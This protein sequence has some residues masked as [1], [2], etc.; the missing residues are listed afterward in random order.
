MKLRE[1]TCFLTAI[2][3]LRSFFGL[4]ATNVKEQRTGASVAALRKNFIFSTHTGSDSSSLIRSCVGT[5]SGGV[6]DHSASIVFGAKQNII[7]VIRLNRV[8]LRPWYV[9]TC[10][11]SWL[12]SCN[13][14]LTLSFKPQT[15]VKENQAPAAD[16]TS[17]CKHDSRA[18]GCEVEEM[19]RRVQVQMNPRLRFPQWIK[20]ALITVMVF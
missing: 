12:R 20:P 14:D 9:F 6:R 7:S 16:Q 15:G 10:F 3:S 19:K 4:R 17:G 1:Q 13:R 2:L 18:A 8:K 11:F 5:A